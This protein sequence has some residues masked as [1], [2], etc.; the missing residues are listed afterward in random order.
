MVRKTLLAL[1][2]VGGCG[3]GVLVNAQ[4]AFR[5]GKGGMDFNQFYAASRLAGT[6][7]LYDWS[8]LSALEAPNGPPIHSGRLPVVSY[9]VKLIGWMPFP[10]ALVVWRAASVAALLAVCAVWPGANRIGF[11]AALAWST[12]AIYIISL[13]QD[14]AFW[15]LFFA[16]GVALM[17]RR[18]ERLAGVAFALCICKYH[19]AAGIPIMLVAQRRWRTLTSGGVTV[20]A[21]LAASFAI[22]GLSWPRAYLRTL[23]SPDFSPGRSMMPNLAGLASWLPGS[24]MLELGA[25]AGVASLLWFT[26]RRMQGAGVAGAAAAACGLILGHH[27]YVQDCALVMPLAVLTIQSRR[28]ALWLRA[29]ASVPVTPALTLL[30]VMGAPLLGQAL[31]IGFVTLAMAPPE[32]SR[33]RLARAIRADFSG[34]I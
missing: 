31:L 13:G 3:L 25:T 11:L 4:L 1:A 27:G 22:E 21:L 16:L 17:D 14:V 19:L 15:L 18:Y 32:L 23:A 2:V 7:H 12:P 30:L 33:S 9:G 10:L 6:G 24:G 29:L 8:A 28:T 20:L 26:C 5:A 34:A